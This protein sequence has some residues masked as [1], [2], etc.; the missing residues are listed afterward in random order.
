MNPFLALCRKELL[1]FFR[2]RGHVLT[3][4]LMPMVFVLLMSFALGGQFEANEGRRAD[5]LVADADDGSIGARVIEGL[6]RVPFLRV[7]ALRV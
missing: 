4:F 5:C 1:V 2:D 7:E 3:T 6:R